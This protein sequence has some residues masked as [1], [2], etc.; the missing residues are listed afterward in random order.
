[1]VSRLII[2]GLV[3]L[4]CPAKHASTHAQ[5]LWILVAIKFARTLSSDLLD[6]GV[7]PCD[8]LLNDPFAIESASI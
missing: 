2:D 3:V 7:A 8:S 4:A 6:C 1:L 5:S